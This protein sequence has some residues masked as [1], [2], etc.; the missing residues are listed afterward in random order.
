MQLFA[1]RTL[2]L[3]L[4]VVSATVAR[5]DSEGSATPGSDLQVE[6]IQIGFSGL[7]KVAEWTPLRLTVRSSVATESRI[8]VESSDSDDNPCLQPGPFYSLAAG[9]STRVESCFR[10]GRQQGE[11]FIRLVD[12]QGRELWKERL[13]TAT[14]ENAPFRPALRH[15]VSLWL[16]FADLPQVSDETSGPGGDSATAKRADSAN[17]P[18]I[19]TIESP[20]D[21]PL[22]PE[23]MEAVDVVFLP[24]GNATGGKSILE[25]LTD[26]GNARLREWVRQGGSLII[27]VGAEE[28]AWRASQL[29]KWVP[30]IVEGPATFRQLTG[31]ESFSGVPSTI[32]LPGLLKGVRLAA[33]PQRNVLVREGG[34]V[35]IASVPYGFGQVT[36]AGLDLFSPPIS[37]WPGLPVVLRK[38]A[39]DAPKT[40]RQD[41]A[42]QTNR[43]LTHTGITDLA[44]QL[45]TAVEDFPGVPRPSHWW[46]MGL[47]A[48]YLLVIGPL[49]Y[50][51]CH[52]VLRRPELTWLTLPVLIGI[53]AFAALSAAERVNAKGLQFNQLDLVDIDS[54][55]GA[56]RGHSLVAL[57]SPENRR[58]A[59]VVK[60][61]SELL[62]PSGNA[63]A[64][65]R[66]ALLSWSGVPENSVSGVYRN[67]GA[68]VGGREYQFTDDGRMVDNLPIF[69]W[70]IKS[71]AADWTGTARDDLVEARLETAGPGQIAGSITHHLPGTLENC[72]LIVGGWAYAPTADNGAIPADIPWKP[73]GPQ[74][75]ARDLKALLTGERRTKQEKDQ[76]RTEVLTT[77]AAYDPLNRNRVD[78]IQ[79]ISFHQ[80]VGDTAYTGLRNAP[81]RHLELTRLSELG[82]GI[83]VGRLKKPL[84]RTKIDESEPEAAQY[85]SF[86]RLVVPVRQIER[87][88]TISIPKPGEQNTPILS[89]SEPSQ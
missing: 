83:L 11:L 68:S 84:A 25:R 82:R 53:G 6:Q 14:S 4:V 55:T 58:F 45:Q 43:Q 29:A 70:S 62:A 85:D 22:L 7:Y 50:Y 61:G 40:A 79:M 1:V 21:L 10:T 47:I 54:T 32:R 31:L 77:T 15:E 35:L 34:G 30:V 27:T 86:V 8:V 69:Q 18:R 39:G 36:F 19:L 59:V 75:R 56:L 41:Q 42:R 87:S 51:L 13:R 24:T 60:P 20:D 64:D 71:L 23:G 88:P 65:E 37:S 28:A 72:L 66:A 44:T 33:L 46:V 81:L 26:D 76:L 57:Y 38:L 52:H 2:V 49:D 73:G 3:G 80:A 48:A 67:G 63:A 17:A 74:G 89:P 5:A 9:V 12:R 78:L 16:T